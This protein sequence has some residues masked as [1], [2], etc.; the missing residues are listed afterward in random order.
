MAQLF[1]PPWRAGRG[2]IPRYVVQPTVRFMRVEA[3]GGIVIVA[4]AGNSG[5]GTDTVI[6]PAR[7][8][9]VIAAA[10]T[11]ITDARAWFSSTGPDV[12]VSGP[13]VGIFSTTNDGLYGFKN[14]TSMASPH[15][16]GTAALFIASGVADTNGNGRINDEVRLVIQATAE[17]LGDSEW[18]GFGLVNAEITD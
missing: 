4:A 14:G 9:S 12:E 8:A 3:A 1:R 15:V 18:F 6:Y 13:G 17:D 16:A 7:F 10:A 5:L 2:P 11:D